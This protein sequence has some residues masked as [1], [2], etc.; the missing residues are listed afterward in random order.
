M[1]RTWS[2]SLDIY[3]H[4]TFGWWEPPFWNSQ[5][6]TYNIW[7][8]LEIFIDIKYFSAP[9]NNLSIRIWESII[10]YLVPVVA[11]FL[12]ANQ[13]GKCSWSVLSAEYPPSLIWSRWMYFTSVIS[14]PVETCRCIYGLKMFLSEKSNNCIFWWSEDWRIFSQLQVVWQ[15]FTEE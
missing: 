15:G 12:L 9:W 7:P 1:I 8:I 14:F 5:E 10:C 6:I 13:R 4:W 11:C 2:H 3:F